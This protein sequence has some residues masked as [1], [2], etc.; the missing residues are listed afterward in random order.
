MP[1]KIAV[2]ELAEEARFASLEGRVGRIL[3]VSEIE[4]DGEAYKDFYKLDKDS[5]KRFI[6][7]KL[8]GKIRNI[9]TGEYITISKQSVLKLASHFKDGE[10]YQKTIAHIPQ[11]IENMKFLERMLAEKENAR[12]DNY[13]YYITGISMDGKSYTVL[14]TVASKGESV[15]YD[16]NVFEGARQEVFDVA[17]STTD[18]K[19]DRLSKILKEGSG[20]TEGFYI[21]QTPDASN[22]EYSKFSD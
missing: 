21:Q 3:D 15:Y 4:L 1:K 2:P 6:L 14:S 11:I 18:S 9:D 22:D 19:Y 16:Q 8:R 5:I 20:G 10:A 17:K 12:F 7:D 13:S